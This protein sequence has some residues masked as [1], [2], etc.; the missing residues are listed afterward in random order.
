MALLGGVTTHGVVPATNLFCTGFGETGLRCCINSCP[1]LLNSSPAFG[2]PSFTSLSFTNLLLATN[3]NLSGEGIPQV[4][5][6]RIAIFVPN[7][8]VTSHAGPMPAMALI[9]SISQ[10]GMNSTMDSW[11]EMGCRLGNMGQGFWG[12]DLSWSRTF[13]LVGHR[14]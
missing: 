9:S 12:K 3:G 13:A 11:Q 10:P 8:S 1:K 14:V 6:L 2:T 7:L 4:F 5:P